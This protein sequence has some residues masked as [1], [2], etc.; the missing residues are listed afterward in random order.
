[1]VP[2]RPLRAAAC[3]LVLVVPPFEPAG[4]GMEL[5]MSLSMK[6]VAALCLLTLPSAASADINVTT[7]TGPPHFQPSASCGHG[8]PGSTWLHTL[9]W[10]P[11]QVLTLFNFREEL[12]NRIPQQFPGIWSFE[13]DP[14]LEGNLTVENYLAFDG[15]ASCEHAAQIQATLWITGGLPANQ[16]FAWMQIYNE[17]GDSG[18]GT[19]RG[20]PANDSQIGGRYMDS[21]PFYYNYGGINAA[22]HSV[23]PD[24]W[25][26]EDNEEFTFSDTPFQRIPDSIVPHGGSVSFML[27][28]A[29]WSGTY[30]PSGNNTVRIYGGLE[31]GFGYECHPVPGPATCAL[32]GLAMLTGSRR[33]RSSR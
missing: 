33:R 12:N 16:Q 22:G 27:M 11:P 19:W 9:T 28:L 5:C 15:P 7:P 24:D 17:T 13:I 20:D 25:Y 30:D 31:W 18:S 14:S 3:V 4:Y 32:L 21:L 1:M 23:R 2:R 10:R 6:S 8:T 29:S 26:D